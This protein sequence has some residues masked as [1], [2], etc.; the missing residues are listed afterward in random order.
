VR[1][2]HQA[3]AKFH[4]RVSDFSAYWQAV[5][6]IRDQY[7]DATAEDLAQDDVCI[8]CRDQMLLADS[9][10]KLPCGHAFHYTCLR[11]WVERQQICPTCR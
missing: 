4:Q 11:T 9:P 8:I 3:F 2:L 5:R 6:N 7:A 1:D 10:K